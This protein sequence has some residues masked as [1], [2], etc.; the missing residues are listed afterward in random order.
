M[1]P[2]GDGPWLGTG[3]G[4]ADPIQL[5]SAQIARKASPATTIT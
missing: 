4:A 5:A 3:A 1:E 2:V